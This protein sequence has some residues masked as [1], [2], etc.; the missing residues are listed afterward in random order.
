MFRKLKLVSI[1]LIMFVCSLNTKAFSLLGPLA[2]WQTTELSYGLSG[3]I[4]GPMQIG[5]FY[6]WNVPVITYAFDASFIN[7]FGAY[8]IKAV[9]DAIK[10]FNDLPPASQIDLQKYP[11]S[12]YRLNSK[13]RSLLLTDMKTFI[14]AELLQELGLAQPERFTWCLRDHW[15]ETVGDQDVRYY[16][17]IKRNF[18]PDTFEPS[19]YV[20]GTLYTYQI[21]H[22]ATPHQADAVE[23]S[24]DPLKPTYTSLAGLYQMLGY[25]AMNLTRDDVGGLRYLLRRQNVVVE[26]LVSN[27][28]GGLNFPWVPVGYSNYIGTNFLGL[29]NIISGT[30]YVNAAYRGGIEK[31][32]F[33]RVEYDPVL[34]QIPNA[35]TNSYNDRY[36]T[37]GVTWSEQPIQL[38]NYAPDI[39]F[40]AADLGFSDHSP[41]A[42][43]KTDAAN[44]VNNSAINAPGNAQNTFGPGIITSPIRITLQKL[45][46]IYY[47]VMETTEADSIPGMNFFFVWGS[48]DGSTNEPIVYPSSRSWRELEKILGY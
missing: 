28:I 2:G 26:T 38:I 12:A 27:V 5:E 6:R 14:M 31:I 13:A 35:I 47:N 15:H 34:N 3:D 21:V 39:V 7:F 48:F 1:I 25:Y 43:L 16:W 36:S 46:P 44:W 30:N 22:S 11:L 42:D 9:E 10:V 19:S 45:G 4:G 24:V 37:N 29:T 23:Y 20:N 18:D 17:V 40:S 8:G 41:L 32:I 33:R